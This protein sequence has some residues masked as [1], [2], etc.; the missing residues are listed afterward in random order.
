MK[1]T[2]NLAANLLLLLLGTE[3]IGAL[4][5]DTFSIAVPDETW[6][7][8]ALLCVLLWIATFFR[9]G[10]LIGMP[11]C[12][13]VL[14]FLYRND[15]E[16]LLLEFQDLLEHVNASY[17]GYFGGN[18]SP[19]PYTD[20]ASGHMTALLFI[21]FLIAAFLAA[22]LA[23]GSF[24]ISLSYLLTVPLFAVCIAVNG[25]P[26][27][28]PV[29]GVL[30]FW[31]GIHLSGD[32]FRTGDGAGKGVLL[33]LIPCAMVLAALL[34]LYN[35]SN[36]HYDETDISLSQRF[37]RLGNALSQWMNKNGMTPPGSSGTGESSLKKYEPPSGWRSGSEDLVLTRSFDYSALDKD[38]FRVTADA[39]SSLYFRG[40]SYGEY[41]GNAWG[42]AV[43]DTHHHALDYTAR[44]L[45]NTRQME[46]RSFKLQ[47]EVPYETV[48]LPYFSISSAENDVKFSVEGLSG[49]DGNFYE[50]FDLFSALSDAGLSGMTADEEKNYREYAHNYYTKLP[51]STRA[52]VAG[53]CRTRGLTKDM[54][55]AALIPAVA[56]LVRTQGI[57]DINA[58]AYTGSDYAVDFLTS[59]RRAYCIHF[60]TAAAVIYRTLG[61]PA[62]ICEGYL[63]TF[64]AGN[65][66]VQD[67]EEDWHMENG[68]GQNPWVNVTGKDAHAWVEVYLDGIGWYPVEVTASQAENP[69]TQS[70]GTEELS[71][72]Q[73]DNLPGET[74]PNESA[75]TP[76]L[77]EAP[78]DGSND[79]TDDAERP[80]NSENPEDAPNDSSE[81]S[82]DAAENMSSSGQAG[83]V[84]G[85]LLIILLVILLLVGAVYG[86][87][88]LLRSS[89]QKRLGET[90]GRKLAISV[91]RQA[92]RLRRWGAEMPDDIRQTAEKAAFSQH[93][94]SEEEKKACLS[95]LEHLTDETW[96]SLNKRQQFVFQYLFAN[97]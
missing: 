28:L 69:N 49:Y 36:Y 18:G 63:V 79:G 39:V 33:G 5:A 38:A 76:M 7:W 52:E 58:E 10:I 41:R 61:I 82:E 65:T 93:E 77:P 78:D 9:R 67:T 3:S 73:P 14:W 57:Y 6:L 40:K 56:E 84:V 37:D 45:L 20:L 70:L 83:K 87:Y 51:E 15:S 89:L 44:A 27:V 11:L 86:R 4:I 74:D 85:R 43:E 72:G 59:P 30:L 54:G 71:P 81:Q 1:K 46:T 23:S 68:L 17:L 29:V 19:Y 21:L 2:L 55:T 97:K 16:D 94:I 92:D 22:S 66:V 75:E 31:C 88:R 8:L 32:S 34:M 60:A 96:K 90:D 50:A 64:P 12:A 25:K 47:S 53:I 42:A 91:Y 80:G 48:Y 95:S 13:L 62:R 24:R 26:P 35:P